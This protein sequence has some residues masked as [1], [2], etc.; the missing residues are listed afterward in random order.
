MITAY[1][2][3][4]D[5]IRVV[6]TPKAAFSTPRLQQAEF[7]V[8]PY[9]QIPM[10]ASGTRAVV[11]RADIGGEDRALRFYT[12]EEDADTRRRYADLGRTLTSPSLLPHVATA[13]WIE[14]AITVRQRQWPMVEMQWVEG[15]TLD[16]YVNFLAGDRHRG[17]LGTLAGEWRELIATLQKARFAHGDLQHGNVLVDTQRKLRL[18]DFD[19]SW[20]E[21][22][23]TN[24][25][26]PAEVGHPNYQR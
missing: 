25:I 15:R 24:M 6:Q 19:G 10:P 11:F 2:T 17:A 21:S 5:Y 12:V 20:I 26:A 4:E 7:A 16:T 13:A 9:L 3:S 8:D 23:S 18:V 22:F 1:P 14:D